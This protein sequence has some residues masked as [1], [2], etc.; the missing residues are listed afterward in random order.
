MIKRWG[1]FGQ[2]LAC[3]G[4][5]ECKNTRPFG[6]EAPSSRRPTRSASACGSPMVVKRGRFGQFLACSR[7]PE[8]KGTRPLLKKVGVACPKDGGEIVEKRSKKGRTFY[9]C[10][11]YPECDFTSWSRPQAGAVPVVRRADRR[12]RARHGEV[13]AVRLEG[14][15]GQRRARTGQSVGVSADRGRQART[16]RTTTIDRRL[17]RRRFL[18]ASAATAGGAAIVAAGCGDGKR[19]ATPVTPEASPTLVPGTAVRGGILRTYNFDALPPETFDPHVVSGGPIVNVHS[20]IFS[21]LLRYADERTGEIA[22]DLVESLPE[23]P[24][25]LTYVFKLRDGVTFHDTPQVRAA[26]APLAGRTLTSADVRYG[27]ERQAA[28]AKGP[29]ARFGRTSQCTVID[30]IETPDDLTVRVRLKTPVAPFMAFLAS[31]QAF[32]VPPEVID[33]GSGEVSGPSAM[34]GSGPFVLESFEHGVAVKL[35][36]NSNWF[37]QADVAGAPRPYLDGYD[38]FLSP[39]QDAFQREAFDGR[40]VDATEFLDPNVFNH[41]RAT[42]LSDIVVEEADAGCSVATRLLVDRPPFNDARVRRALHLAIDRR[43]LA[44]LVY[45]PVGG[46]ASAR[47]TGPIAPGSTSWSLTNED[48]TRLPGYAEDRTAALAEAK[49]LWAAATGDLPVTEIRAVV[50]GVPR[51]FAEVALPALQRQLR[52]VLGVEV[53]AQVDPSGGALI[54]AALRRNREGASEGTIGFTFA[55]EDGGVDL[56]DWVYGAVS[57]RRARQYLPHAG[58][59]ARFDA[60]RAAWR[61]RCGGA[62]GAGPRHPGVPAGERERAHRLRVAVRRRLAWGYARNYRL[63]MWQGSDFDLADTWLDTSHAA[64]MGRPV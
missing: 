18:A 37:A 49:Q 40:A 4:F 53:T 32:I 13:H 43:A 26:F 58:R 25:E 6:D 11:N 59:D 55:I 39:Q 35:R 34:I 7:Y 38:A 31:R 33:A 63:P 60:G 1:R 64:W 46:E 8:C 50:S 24:D 45:P 9:A 27:I 42:N 22:P 56:D 29:G 57:Q 12:C 28:E 3:S 52:E 62:A 36:R 20:A 44:T 2:F 17:T 14:L 15:R 30:R 16:P 23:Q 47:V 21:K 19:Q 51:T 5:P 48:L 61:V 54:A 10:A 41:A